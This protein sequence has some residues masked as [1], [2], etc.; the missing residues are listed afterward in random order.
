MS[1]S[2]IGIIM[3]QYFW[4]NNAFYVQ[5]EKFNSLVYDALNAATNRLE[6]EQTATFFIERFSN[7]NSNTFIQGF[8]LP[9]FP[10]PQQENKNI[11]FNQQNKYESYVEAHI[12][13]KN[14]NKNT[15]QKQ[16][17]TNPNDRYNAAKQALNSFE[18]SINQ[19]KS[20]EN[21]INRFSYELQ[22]RRVNTNKTVNAL[23]LEN[24]IKNELKIRG[25][26]LGFQFGVI[27]RTNK[28][29][30][31]IK[32]SKYNPETSKFN[33]VCNLFPNDI[34]QDWRPFIVDVYFEGEDFFI[35]KSLNILFSLSLL[36]TICILVTFYFTLKIILSQKKLSEIKNDFINNMTHEF[37]T[38]I[39]TINLATDSIANP[40]IINT[41]AQIQPFL[42]IIKEE[43]KRMNNQVERV[44]QMSMIEKDDFKAIKQDK[45]I[46]I[47]IQNAIEK[48]SLL[49]KEKN[50]KIIS[51]LNAQQTNYFI[52]EI[53][54]TNVIMNLMENAL[55][56]SKNNPEIEISTENKNNGIIISVKDNGIG[57]TKEQ[58]ARIFDKFFRVTG[59]NIHN[60]KGFGLG[61]S[62]VK[63]VM[64]QH[65]GSISVKSKLNE[66]SVF[67]LFIPKS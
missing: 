22:M 57:M 36:F 13:I 21:L 53:H 1:I 48:I 12:E 2:L 20:V 25:I 56:Y 4:M 27:N 63:A 32:S 64:L 66:G 28:T 23:Q 3:V 8:N 16:F 51:N 46:N 31:E 14:R 55:K 19:S 58:Q 11:Q 10:Q 44:L 18:D 6:R 29:L 38:P 50:A 62:Y 45:D 60:V 5:K 39:A 52:D 33:F 49:A 40:K 43:N 9:N 35:F 54:I 26:D 65:N 67:S 42:N 24:L 7:S 47:I 37:K 30:T 17:N 59:G 41:P 15:T 61:L 34:F